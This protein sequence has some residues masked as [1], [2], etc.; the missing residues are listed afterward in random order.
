MLLTIIYHKE[1]IPMSIH[2]VCFYGEILRRMYAII[3]MHIQIYLKNKMNNFIHTSLK[4]SLLRLW[5]KQSNFVI[6]ISNRKSNFQ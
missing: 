4:K 5:N 6:Y 3:A 1:A 2:K